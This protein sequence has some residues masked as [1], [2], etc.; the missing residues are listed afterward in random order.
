MTQGFTSWAEI[1]KQIPGRNMK[2]CRERW[3]HRLDPEISKAKFTREEDQ[4]I[5]EMHKQYGNK[6]SDISK[7]L[8]GRTEDAVKIRF[9]SI[10]RYLQRG[11]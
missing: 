7:H 2:Q 5:I 3:C 9:R 11:E 1:A 4:I 10:E 6:W 8:V